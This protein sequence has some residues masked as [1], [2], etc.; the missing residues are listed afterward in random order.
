MLT[1]LLRF[2]WVLI[3]LM[4]AACGSGEQPSSST[5]PAAGPAQA[6][7]DT[8]NGPGVIVGTITFEGAPP[9]VRPLRMDADPRCVAEPGAASEVLVVGPGEGLKN[10]FVYVKDGL[11]DRRYATPTEPVHLNQQGCRY[12]PHVF[13]VQVG[14]PVLIANSDPTLHNVNANPKNNRPFNFGQVPKTPAVTRVFDKPEVAVPFRCDVHS[15]MNAYAGVVTH[16]FFAV[17]KEDGSF[18]IKGLPAGTY[19]IEMWHEQLGTQT[20]SVTVDGQTPAKI[21]AAFKRTT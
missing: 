13:G 14:Q 18:E 17:T 8:A 9:A 3:L 11:G 4:A 7:S 2:S 20:Q 15:W 21:S 6:A 5:A 1:R 12:V 16:P 19:T 10:V